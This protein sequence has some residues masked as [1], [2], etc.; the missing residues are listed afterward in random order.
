MDTGNT[1]NRV[2]VR[3][4]GINEY[5]RIVGVWLE[6]GLPF[7]PQGRDSRESMDLELGLSTSLLLLAEADG[8]VVGTVLGTHDGRKGWINRL[9]VVP[10]H[11]GQGL[12]RRL[13][14]DVETWLESQGIGICAALVESGNAVSR[15]FFARIGYAHDPDIEYFSKRRDPQT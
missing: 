10:D 14:C 5:D 3:E 6:A 15:G 12:A 8:R 2:V 4:A 11:R 13:V 7:R 9:A 1:R